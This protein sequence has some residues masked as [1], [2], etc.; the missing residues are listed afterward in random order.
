MTELSRYASLR[1]KVAQYLEGR[2]WRRYLKR[3]PPSK[4]LEDKID[5]WRRTLDTLAWHPVPGRRV[6][7]AGCGPAGIFIHLHRTESVAALDP[8]LSN[9]ERHL[10]IFSRRSYPA[11]SFHEQRLED[12]PIHAGPFA[13]IYCFN[14]INHVANWSGALDALTAYARP[15]TEMI[16]T[17]DV[18]RW[19]WLMPLFRAI[20]GDALHPQQ[21]DAADYRYALAARGWTIQREQV[22]RREWIFD[23]TAWVARYEGGTA[24]N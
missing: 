20:P 11:V 2:W 19:N 4:Y 5:Y 23:Y 10:P 22:L 17:S 9:Y 8:L 18:H 15:G 21:H 12:R 24:R 6:L 7:D 14:A 13:A 1:W 3:K 16:L